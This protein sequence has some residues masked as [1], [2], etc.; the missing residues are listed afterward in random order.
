MWFSGVEN[1]DRIEE[2]RGGRRVRIPGSQPLVASQYY[3]T[4]GPRKVSLSPR[5]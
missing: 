4:V 1:G 5:K 3:V 2:G